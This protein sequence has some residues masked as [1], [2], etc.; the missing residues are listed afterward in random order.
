MRSP[1]IGDWVLFTLDNGEVRPALC[2]NDAGDGPATN[3]LV[4]LDGANDI[5]QSVCGIGI[6]PAHNNLLWLPMVM[7]SPAVKERMALE[8]EEPHP[9]RWHR[10][11]SGGK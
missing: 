10:A 9:G 11:K 5:G 8:G 1:A 4:F 7:P 6:P 3:L 2:V